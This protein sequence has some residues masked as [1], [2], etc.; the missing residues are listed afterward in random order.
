MTA[1]STNLVAKPLATAFGGSVAIVGMAI[2][3]TNYRLH[4]RKGR[5]PVV[6][7]GVEKDFPGAVLAVLSAGSRYNEAIIQAAIT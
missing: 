2:A 4:R 3:F 5:I 6:A 7:T 1:W